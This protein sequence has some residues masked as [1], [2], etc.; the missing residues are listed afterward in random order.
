MTRYH[1][2]GI[3]EGGWYLDTRTLAVTNLAARGRLP[4]SRRSAFVRVPWP[5]LL[6][7]APLVG[8]A[9]LVA[10]PVVGLATAAGG[11]ARRAAAAGSRGLGATLAPGGAPGE[12]HLTGKPGRGEAGL[13]AGMRD[14]EAQ[15]A[16]RRR[17]A[18]RQADP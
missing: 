2:G 18:E 4:G 10:A 14:L 16:G 13:D 1:G 11:L 12:A 9:W 3:V 8:G 17:E 15:V 7:L 5:A 6:L